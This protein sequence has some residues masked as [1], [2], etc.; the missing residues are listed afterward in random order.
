MTCQSRDAV[1]AGGRPLPGAGAAEAG[2]PKP[3]SCR[4]AASAARIAAPS[5]CP[6][7]IGVGQLDQ[8]ARQQRV[9][10]QPE[11]R[12]ERG[13]ALLV[14]PDCAARVSAAHVTGSGRR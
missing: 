5:G 13:A 1:G 2:R 12:R 7:A 6:S 11:P 8:P 3:K 4:L 9:G 14:S 10:E